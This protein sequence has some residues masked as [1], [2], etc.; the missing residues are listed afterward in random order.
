MALGVWTLTTRVVP[1]VR[2][3]LEVLVVLE[4]RAVLEVRTLTTLVVPAARA[5]LEV[6]LVAWRLGWLR[7]LAGRQRRLRRRLRRQLAPG[8]P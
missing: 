2:A 3:V 8:R 6:R 7:R 1:V 5:V 4:A